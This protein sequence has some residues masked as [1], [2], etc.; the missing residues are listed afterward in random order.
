[1]TTGEGKDWN[2]G[3]NVRDEYKQCWALA[4]LNLQLLFCQGDSMFL[5]CIFVFT[6][7]NASEI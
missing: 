5:F 4:A 6:D 3:F 1:M 7:D 2:G